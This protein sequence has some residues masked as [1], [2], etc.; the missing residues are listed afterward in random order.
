MDNLVSSLH[1]LGGTARTA[2]L[3]RA[4]C[5]AAAIAGALAA[6]RIARI[7]RGLLTLPEADPAVRQAL[8]ASGLI[9]CASAVRELGLWGLKD[10]DRLHLW[11]PHGRPVDAERHRGLLAGSPGPGPYAPVLD[12]VLHALR[13]RPP[14]EALVIAESAVFR[15]RLG[16]PDLLAHLP[17]PRNGPA[18]ALV[19]RIGGP[20][21]PLQVLARELFRPAGLRVQTQVHLDGIGRVDLLVQ[22]RLVVELDGFDFHWTRPEFRKDRRRSNAGV[23][24]GFPTLRYIYEDLVF[25]ADRAVAEVLTVARRV[26]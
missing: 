1:R 16:V 23:L 25:E 10:P 8:A 17:G 3:V 21:S 7:R 9:T 4:G 19:R 15:G 13:C 24:S 6:G 2:D 20:E 5:S 11:V 22:G 18:R 26:A 12:A 14:L